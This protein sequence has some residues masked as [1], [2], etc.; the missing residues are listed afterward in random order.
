MEYDKFLDQY[1]ELLNRSNLSA[2]ERRTLQAAWDAIEEEVGAEAVT[3]CSPHDRWM[4]DH[5]V[6][7]YCR[8]I[9][10]PKV[11]LKDAKT[12][13]ASAKSFRA[14]AEK[15]RA[16]LLELAH[17][18]DGISDAGLN[19]AAC[20]AFDAAAPALKA[21]REME[22]AA[23]QMVAAARAAFPRPSRNEARRKFV[24]VMLLADLLPLEDFNLKKAA[25]VAVAHV[26]EGEIGSG[27][28][29]WLLPMMRDVLSEHG[30][31]A[32]TDGIHWQ[33]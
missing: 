15:I 9:R 14:K 18:F 7:Q 20:G 1:D 30:L 27:E 10:R 28:G 2:E 29:E 12:A 11:A 22:L 17:G 8:S 26:V 25:V 23:E 6:L 33:E 32:S 4:L 19:L 16:D 5:S 13:A 3:G 31:H 21:A 24:R